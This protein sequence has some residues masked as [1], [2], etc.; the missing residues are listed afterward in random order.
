MATNVAES[1]VESQVLPWLRHLLK[2]CKRLEDQQDTAWRHAYGIAQGTG[3]SLQNRQ[4]PPFP[5]TSG[6]A[7]NSLVTGDKV[8]REQGKPAQPGKTADPFAG[9]GPEFSREGLPQ[10]LAARERQAEQLIKGMLKQARVL[11]ASDP[12]WRHAYGIAQGFGA[13]RRTE[14]WPPFPNTEGSRFSFLVEQEKK[15]K[16]AAP[17]PRRPTAAGP[18]APPTLVD[19][20]EAFRAMP[21]MLQGGEAGG[22]AGGEA[23]R[24]MPTMMD[25]GG[26]AG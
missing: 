14:L 21:T 22:G 11:D 1:I 20:G 4:W 24:A 2:E 16:A 15:A 9:E 23:F 7:F 3:F 10:G 18:E 8:R 5:T 6:S 17:A 26:E 19:G 13:L 25:A 12:C